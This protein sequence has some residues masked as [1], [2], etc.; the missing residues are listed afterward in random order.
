M[1]DEDDDAMDI[2]IDLA[3]PIPAYRQIVDQAR[4]LLVAG[5]LAPGAS[6]P[7]VRRLAT[8]LGVHHNTVAEAYRTLAD[9][10]WLEVA[11]GKAV[12]VVKRAAGAQLGRG[13]QE[14]LAS[15]FERRIRHLVAELRARGLSGAALARRLRLLAEEME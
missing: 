12:R 3:S 5:R 4:H 14:E 11:Q 6:L 15:G 9:E 13:E 10:G 2:V 1:P 7:S 8:D